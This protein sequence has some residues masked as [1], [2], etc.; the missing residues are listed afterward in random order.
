MQETLNKIEENNKT[1]R[2]INKLVE[3]YST[4]NPEKGRNSQ[5]YVN[6]QTE[7]V[8]D[9]LNIKSRLID[10][11]AE[12]KMDLIV[13]TSSIF[14]F[15]EEAALISKTKY[16]EKNSFISGNRHFFHLLFYS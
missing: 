16:L 2:Q 15:D 4:Q 7:N 11:I 14:R 3:K 8:S 1:I 10:N 6:G 12:F 9:I 13:E 5:V